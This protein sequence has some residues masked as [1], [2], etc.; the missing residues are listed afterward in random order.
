MTADRGI[1]SVHYVFETAEH[2]I[3]LSVQDAAHVRIESWFPEL[4]ERSILEQPEF[5]GITWTVTRRD[6][7]DQ[8][9][10]A[11]VLHVRNDDEASFD[12]H[13]GSL[14]Q[15]LLRGQ[16]LT[17]LSLATQSAMLRQVKRGGTP[18]IA[19]IDEMV[20]QLRSPSRGRRMLADRQLLS[21]G[22]PIVPV[23]R[24]TLTQDLDPE[25]RD[26]VRA[27][28]RRLRPRVG[29][30]PASLAKLFV[31]DEAYWNRIAMRLDTG[32]IELAN[33]HLIQFGATPLEHS[34]LAERRV[35]AKPSLAGER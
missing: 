33:Q 27:I 13:F 4:A 2:H 1:P 17:E 12:R 6:L 8:H 21:W 31:N 18:T 10:G 15:R 22:T 30:T 20:E 9:E 5:G 25:Q 11:T 14:V 23:L 34:E 29:D 32:Q 28:L 16:S 3:T 35:A 19:A 26:R 24:R 7:K